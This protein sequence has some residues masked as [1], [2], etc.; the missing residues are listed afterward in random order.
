MDRWG[1][2]K[3]SWRIKDLRKRLETYRRVHRIKDLC[4]D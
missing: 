2:W 1:A 4:S 3:V